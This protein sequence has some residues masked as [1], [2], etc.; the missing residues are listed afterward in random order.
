MRISTAHLPMRTPKT[1][2]PDLATYQLHRL[3]RTPIGVA[4]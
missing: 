4:I 3:I 2:I 1:G